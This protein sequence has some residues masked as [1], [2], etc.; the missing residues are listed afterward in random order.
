MRIGCRSLVC[1]LVD[2]NNL[3]EWIALE[4]LSIQQIFPAVNHHAKLRAPVADVIVSDHFMPEKLRDARQ[5]VAKHRA[6]DVTDVHRLGH[7]G[8]S[9]IDYDPPR[10]FCLCNTETFVSQDFARFSFDCV[11]TQC[12]VDET[13]AR[14]HWR[15]AKIANIK[16]RKNFLREIPWIFTALF[17]KHESGVRLIIAETGIGRGR[18]FARIRQSGLCQRLRKLLCEK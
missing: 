9:K 6:A 12:E 18:K 13:C 4:S 15:F 14:N 2:A 3:G 5:R 17:A 8:R 16:L 7:V 11:G 10:R 1:L